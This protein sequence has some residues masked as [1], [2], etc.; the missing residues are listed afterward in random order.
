MQSSGFSDKTLTC[1]DC[2]KE[3]VWT[4]GE[5]EFYQQ[6]GFENPPFRCPD[7]RQNRKMDRQAN[8]PKTKITC[9]KC[10]KEDEVPFVPRNGTDVLCRDCFKAQREGN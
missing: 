4:A 10:G 9:A 1:K 2:N 3:F 7:C 6:K 5:Q 8:R